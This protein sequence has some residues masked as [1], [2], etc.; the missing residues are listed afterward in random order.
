VVGST[1]SICPRCRRVLEGELVERDRRVL[2]SRSCPVHGLF[3]AV[4]YGDAKRYLEIQR[5]AKPGEA[6]RQRQ[7]EESKGCPHDVARFARHPLRM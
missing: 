4:V 2:L 7:T 1:T 3:E 6:P 5:F